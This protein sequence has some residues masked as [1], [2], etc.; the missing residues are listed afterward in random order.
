[1]MMDGKLRNGIKIMQI[2]LLVILAGS[3]LSCRASTIVTEKEYNSQREISYSSTK[4]NDSVISELRRVFQ[5]RT[6]EGI[7]VFE[8]DNE[9]L[10]RRTATNLAVAELAA[11]VQTMVRAESVV[12][13][14]KDVRDV[15]ENRVHAL[16]NNYRIDFSGY[17]PGT[18]KY[19]VRAIINGEDLVREVETQISR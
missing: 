17:D 6:L 4:V 8:N 1:M 5:K 2:F 14:N 10:A 11:K 18:K 9:G 19:R 12:Y 3:F 16:V 15:V 7:G 13:N